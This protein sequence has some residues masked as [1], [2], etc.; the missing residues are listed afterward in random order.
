M[1]AQGFDEESISRKQG[2]SDV[3]FYD[4]LR[5]QVSVAMLYRLKQPQPSPRSREGT[6]PTFGWESGPNNW[7]P[8][9]SNNHSGMKPG[10]KKTKLWNRFFQGGKI[11]G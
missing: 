8:I 6:E 9:I 3:A 10:G 2:Q 11:Q 1:A 7:Q 5:S 4:S